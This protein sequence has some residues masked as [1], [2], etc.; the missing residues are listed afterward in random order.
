MTAILNEHVW[1]VFVALAAFFA[2]TAVLLHRLTFGSRTRPWIVQLDGIVPNFFG[3]VAVLFGLF[4]GFVANDAWETQRLSSRAILAE[5]DALVAAYQLSIAT[6]S[7]MSS[8]RG[9]I[10]DYLRS[11]LDNEWVLMSEGGSSRET[12]EALG[13]LLA[14]VADPKVSAEAGQV[15]HAEILDLVM[16]V[17]TARSDRLSL[18][19]Q[20][21]DTS[22]WT[23]VLVLALLTQIGLAV[24]HIQKPRSQIAVLAIFSLAVVSTLGSISVSARPY[25]YRAAASRPLQLALAAMDRPAGP[26]ESP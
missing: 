19:L 7:D 23:N 24:V 2:V 4:T 5:R 17:R 26:V 25:T 18:A 22:K 20:R 13:V 14:Q 8:I 6:V 11:V 1:V 21:S 16:R 10:R 3:S 15:V 12:T 9:A